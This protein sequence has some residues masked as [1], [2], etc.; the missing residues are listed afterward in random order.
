MLWEKFSKNK[1]VNKK[2]PDIPVYL[3][4]IGF[5]RKGFDT[6]GEKNREELTAFVKA[7]QHPGGCFTDRAGNPDLYYSLFGVLL[8]SALNIPGAL[9][10]HKQFIKQNSV[11]NKNPV[12]VFVIMLIK[13]LLFGNNYEHPSYFK[14][15]KLAIGRNRGTSFF[16]RLFLFLL[17]T[18]AF[19]RKKV[20]VV[21]AQLGIFFYTPQAESPCSIYAAYT[22]VRKKAGMK[23][24]KEQLKLYSFYEE[25]KGFKAFPEAN[26]ADM[27]STAVALFALKTT[28]ADLR[29]AAPGCLDF[30][31]Q[32]YHNGAFLAGTGD[33]GRDLEY[34]FYALLA[35]GTLV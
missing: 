28:G 29:M 10:A 32:N 15:L 24:Q 13:D 26:E 17:V 25:A 31:Q 22:V 20:T 30:I 14:I 2:E 19:Y 6:L 35:L 33:R 12:D 7:N 23:T 3:S 34:T 5:I 27:L 9:E 18:D 1:C 16:Y 4:F 11:Q 21:F 8:A